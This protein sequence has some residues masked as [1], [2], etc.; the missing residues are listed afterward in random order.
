MGL[1]PI[2][3]SRIKDYVAD[4]FGLCDCD[5]ADRVIATIKLIDS[6]FVAMS[7][8]APET[9]RGAQQTVRADDA[10]GVKA[11]FRRLSA[12]TSKK[13]PDA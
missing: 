8:S 2:P 12:Q 7:N 3:Y 1:G 11:M 4:E 13:K 10:G 9:G 5:R 6:A